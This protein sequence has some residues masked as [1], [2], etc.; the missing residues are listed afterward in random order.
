MPKGKNLSHG[1]PLPASF[2]P[3]WHSQMRAILLFGDRVSFR[4]FSRRDLAEAIADLPIL[5][6]HDS[7]V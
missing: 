2:L 7:R 1:K 3:N 4:W 6:L 5:V